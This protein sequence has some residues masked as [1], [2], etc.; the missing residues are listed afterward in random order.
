[1][2]KTLFTTVNE[3]KSLLGITGTALDAAL[4]M[5]LQA[6]VNK[7]CD[8]IGAYEIMQFTVTDEEVEAHCQDYLSPKHLP[9]DWEETVTVKTSFSNP[10]TDTLFRQPGELRTIR[11]KDSDGNILAWSPGTI[12][13]V[14]YTAGF[15][16]TADVPT[17]LKMLAALIVQASILKVDRAAMSRVGG[18]AT[19]ATGQIKKYQ[20][21][22]KSVEY[23]DPN[24][25]AGASGFG[26]GI[27]FEKTAMEW[28]ARFK[29]FKGYA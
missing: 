23:F 19:E 20:I 2:N 9:I 13:L 24:T 6:A 11:R 21:G 8:L 5:Y 28:A 3:I 15:A 26:A 14:S 7:V 27:D 18:N 4:S 22:T 10:V 17:E 29:K 12:Y 16:A 25:K 1:M